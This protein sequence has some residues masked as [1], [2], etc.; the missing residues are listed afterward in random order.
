M[1]LAFALN[2]MTTPKLGLDAFLSL[3][4]ELGME[5]VEIRNDLPGVAL[6]DGTPAD[7]VRRAAADAGVAILSINALQRFNEWTP[8]RESEAVELADYAAACGSR[9]IVLCPVCDGTAADQA[10]LEAA[11]AALKPILAGRGLTGLVEPLGFGFSSLRCKADAA[12]AIRAVGGETTFRLVHDTFHHHIAGESELFPE[13]TGLVHIS[14]VADP[15][16]AVADMRDPHRV[17]VGA[18]DRLGNVE[19][20]AALRRGGYAGPLSFE[21]FAPEVHA[22]ADPAAALSD[23]IAF[24]E[25]RLDRAAA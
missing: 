16:V 9:G 10:R 17:L 25:A 3:A 4:R 15:E 22:L 1:A 21:P 8:E 20:V 6:A 5:A 12:A 2:H 19:Q 13:L 23:S 14:G 11:L 24:I 18:D 7:A